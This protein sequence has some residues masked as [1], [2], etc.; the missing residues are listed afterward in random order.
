MGA[1]TPGAAH[2]PS[3]ISILV[4]TSAICPPESPWSLL[5][6]GTPTANYGSALA[7]GQR[8]CDS[9]QRRKEFSRLGIAAPL[10]AKPLGTDKKAR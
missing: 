1:S 7:P 3:T 10:L 8:A 4:R 9:A 5:Q 6:P 2:S